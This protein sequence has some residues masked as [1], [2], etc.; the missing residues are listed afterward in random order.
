MTPGAAAK[1]VTYLADRAPLRHSPRLP[2]HIDSVAAYSTVPAA[3]D[4]D[5]AHFVGH[6]QLRAVRRG[7]EETGTGVDGRVATA[8]PSVPVTPEAVLQLLAQ[9]GVDLSSSHVVVIG[10]SRIVGTPLAHALLAA[11]ATVSIAHRHTP[12][13]EALCRS[14]DVV[15]SCAGVPG[16][17]KGGWIRPG[18]AVVNVGITYCAQSASLQPDLEADLEA[19]R[20]ARFVASAPGG[21]GPLS[22]ALLFRNVADAAARRSSE[23][24]NQAAATG[25]PAAGADSQTPQANPA[26]LDAFLQEHPHWSV[27]LNGPQRVPHKDLKPLVAAGADGSLVPPVRSLVRTF[28]LETHGDAVALLG[29]AGEIGDRLDHHIAHSAIEHRC[30]Q[31]VELTVHAYTTSTGEITAH[32][33]ELCRQIEAQL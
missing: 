2:S 29:S 19:F 26:A 17:V 20:H 15:V 16:L 6:G 25:I 24:I 22:L 1:P 31:G 28:E 8:V 7:A 30:M 11:D 10:R 13:L 3:L 27:G 4:V 9:A 21:V 32:D 33:L 14:A 23:Q 12:S 5:G 18:G